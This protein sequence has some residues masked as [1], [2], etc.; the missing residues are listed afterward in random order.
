MNLEQYIDANI[1]A[2]RYLPSEDVQTLSKSLQEMLPGNSTL[3]VLGNGGSASTASHA[4]A[5]LVKTISKPLGNTIRTVA[6][7]EMVS[8]QT[9]YSNDVSFESGFSESLKL[10][11]SPGDAILIISVSGLSPNL[12]LAAS[13]ARELGLKVFSLVG[14]RGREIASQS[15]SAIVVESD[16]YQVVENLHLLI[17]HW[18]VKYLEN[19]EI[20]Q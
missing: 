20:N 18:L 2:M 7:S 14:A 1:Q 15:D 6:I 11:A 8:L 16:D 4:V 5:D 3:W 10:L 9:A 19:S 12:V 13:T 17:V